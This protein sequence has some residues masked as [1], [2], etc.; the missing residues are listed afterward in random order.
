M[1]EGLYPR[2]TGLIEKKIQTEGGS[3]EEMSL[4]DERVESG[5][6]WLIV[7]QLNCQSAG[8]AIGMRKEPGLLGNVV[9]PAS[10]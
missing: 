6:D 2:W 1:T 8:C 3:S 10:G 7:G 4:A 9:C 5:S